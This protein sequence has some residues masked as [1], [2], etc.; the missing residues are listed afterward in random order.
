M[1]T[2]SKSKQVNMVNF[3]KQYKLLTAA[4]L[5]LGAIIACMIIPPEPELPHA[6]NSGNYSFN[7]NSIFELLAQG[8]LDVFTPIPEVPSFPTPSASYTRRMNFNDF[9]VLAQAFHRWQWDEPIS[10]WN[11]YELEYQVDC[12]DVEGGPSFVSIT[13]F[14]ISNSFE[15]ETRF[16]HTI[17]IGHPSGTIFWTEAE[18]Y[19]VNENWHAIDL[20][21]I[22]IS[23]EDALKI[24]DENGGLEA[25][26]SANN[27][28]RIDVLAPSLSKNEWL[29]EYASYSS[30]DGWRYLLEVYVDKE[31]GEFRIVHP[32]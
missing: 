6:E 21:Q 27:N 30:S 16:V 3:G 31:S 28:C 10:N 23:A 32:E 1:P 2:S 12:E 17:Q 14:K 19:P 8:N 29:V 25:R 13:L 11:L 5:I 26:L 18:R 24:A 20:T 22:K 7:E 9:L 15:K 4:A